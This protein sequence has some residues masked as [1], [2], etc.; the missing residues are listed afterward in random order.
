V[1][2]PW[3]DACGRWFAIARLRLDDVASK[4]ANRATKNASGLSISS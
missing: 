3:W 1:L 2:S 4:E